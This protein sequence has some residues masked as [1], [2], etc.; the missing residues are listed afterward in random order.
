MVLGLLQSK[1]D[2]SN[3]VNKFDSMLSKYNF[4]KG[5]LLL[6]LLVLVTTSCVCDEDVV[7]K[8]Q[9]PSN[10]T[11]AILISKNCGALDS[12]LVEVYVV[13]ESSNR[14]IFSGIRTG[15][16]DENGNWTEN[17]AI[18]WENNDILRVDY[19]NYLEQ[20]DTYLS[21][22]KDIQIHLYKDGQKVTDEQLAIARHN[23]ETEERWHEECEEHPC[24]L[25]PCSDFIGETYVPCKD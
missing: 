5:A 1:N 12:P 4:L 11:E 15:D 19:D 7:D 3:M 22:Y 25:L 9:S 24:P 21:E 18:K 17:T 16:P 8:V 2:Y 10:K 6:T 20:I 13:M 23:R 14:K